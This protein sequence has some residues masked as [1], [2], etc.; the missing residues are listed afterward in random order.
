MAGKLEI[1]IFVTLLSYNKL[2]RFCI[3]YEV[4]KTVTVE[5]E[6]DVHMGYTL[7]VKD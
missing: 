7:F 2:L 5:T 6:L 3:I 1:S 4:L